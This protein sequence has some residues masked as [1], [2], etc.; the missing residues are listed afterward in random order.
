MSVAQRIDQF[1]PPTSPSQQR[2]I[3][4]HIYRHPG[5][6]FDAR[7]LGEAIGGLDMSCVRKTLHKLHDADLIA[8]VTPGVRGREQATYQALR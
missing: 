4:D 7:S 6:V 2:V 5:E 3:V 1:A 8:Q